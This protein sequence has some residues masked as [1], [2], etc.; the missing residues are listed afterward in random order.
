MLKELQYFE[1]GSNTEKIELP[2]NNE[3]KY[4]PITPDLPDE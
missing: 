1:K 4:N 3:M 2:K